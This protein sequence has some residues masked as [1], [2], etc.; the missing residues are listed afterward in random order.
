M[1]RLSF[2]A[3]AL[4]TLLLVGCSSKQTYVLFDASGCA[5][6]VTRMPTAGAAYTTWTT[7]DS[8]DATVGRVPLQDKPTCTRGYHDDLKSPAVV[9]EP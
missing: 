3:M 6:A 8:Y 7:Y 9:S 1:K 5:F 2:A 4:I